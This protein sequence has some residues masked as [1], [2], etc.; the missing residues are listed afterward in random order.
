MLEE[1]DTLFASSSKAR[2]NFKL[3]M[4]LSSSVAVLVFLFFLLSQLMPDLLLMGVIPRTGSGLL[5]IV[6]APWLH[7]SWGHVSSNIIPLWVGLTLMLYLYPRSSIRSLG[8]IY[9][10]AG[11]LTWLVGRDAIHLGASGIVFGILSF[12]LLSGLLRRDRRALAVSLFIVF[13]Y[14]YIFWGV[15]PLSQDMSWEFHLSGV[16][17]GCLCA[18]VFR[19]YDLPPMKRYD[20]EVDE[21][22]ESLEDFDDSSQY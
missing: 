16:V 7:A 2:A 19:N 13:V 3:A 11:T 12:L 18:V 10:G 4:M 1:P 15:F 8:A 5:G 21:G 14:G 6:A 20:W 22:S 9:F 17:M